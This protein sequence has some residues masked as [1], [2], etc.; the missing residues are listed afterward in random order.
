T[1][2]NNSDCSLHY[3]LFIDQ[4][5]T[6]PYDDDQT[7]RDILA[8]EISS[9]SGVIPARTSQKITATAYPSRRIAYQFKLSYELLSMFDDGKPFITCSKRQLTELQCQGVYPTLSVTDARCLGSGKGYSKVHIWSLFSLESLN[10]CLESDPSPSELLYAAV[11]RHS[12]RRR[13]PVNTRAIMDFNFGA[14]PL[15]VDPCVVH[16]NLKN[17]GSVPSEWAFLFPSDLQLELEYWAETGEYDEDELHE[18]QVMDNKLFSIEP[19]GGKLLPGESHT[20]TLTYSHTVIG[21]NRLP[22]L[23][24]VMRGR[25]ILVNFVGVTVDPESY[26][27][28]FP[29]TRHL[30]EPVPVGGTSPPVQVYEL[31]NGGSRAVNYELDMEPLAQVQAQ[32]YGCRIFECLNPS[33]EIPPGCFALI[34]WQFAPL[35]A[36][37][38]MVDIPVRIVGGETVL[39][40]FTGVGYDQRIMGDTLPVRDMGCT[41][42]PD[43]QVVQVPKQ[44]SYLSVECISFGDVPLYAVSHRIFFLTNSSKDHIISFRWLLEGS[45]LEQVVMIEPDQGFLKPQQTVLLKISFF[46]CGPPSHYDMDI[47]C[48]IVDE[49]EMAEYNH[50]LICWTNMKE[51]KQY[52]FTITENDLKRPSS[53]PQLKSIKQP[54]RSI[55]YSEGDLRKYQALPPIGSPRETTR[56]KRG[57]ATRQETP[58]PP[59]PPETFLLHLG[60]TARTHS[61]GEFNRKFSS[62]V[63]NFVI[64]QRYVLAQGS[65]GNQEREELSALVT[66]SRPEMGIIQNVLSIIL[67]GLLDDDNFH[68]RMAEISQEPVPYFRQLCETQYTTSSRP[69]SASSQSSNQSRSGEEVSGEVEAI[70]STS[71]QPVGEHAQD[72][73]MTEERAV[74]RTHEIIQRTSQSSLS[75]PDR[76]IE[77]GGDPEMN[78]AQR[79]GVRRLPEFES[80][81]ETMLENTLLNLLTEANRGEVNLTSRTRVIAL[82]PNRTSKTTR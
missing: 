9:Q 61:I 34:Y 39:V 30:F 76:L 59:V 32:N 55:S 72:D 21:T 50:K 74:S 22:V 81:V 28:H 10:E 40:T 11:T 5:V 71:Q 45:A 27:V 26:Y 53:G 37:T 69:S 44:L 58:P 52:T 24:K 68:Q 63:D 1:I 14:A 13:V 62:S 7:A 33:G 2:H 51:E 56:K 20:V 82:P 29:T 4:E 23:F 49:T 54:N 12:T 60:V 47:V 70:P 38:Y 19:R 48:E 66:C 6:G 42:V 46:S 67:R 43:K 77:T 31:Y 80:L 8:L 78:T 16:L 18:M 75:I 25:E 65:V 35:E 17:T 36:R 64:D 41:K 57:T 73:T 15:G 79:Q 3:N